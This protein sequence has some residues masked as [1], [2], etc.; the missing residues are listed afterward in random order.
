M[1]GFLT[2][3]FS[4]EEIVC[5]G[6]VALCEP[7]CTG[8]ANFFLIDWQSATSTGE[9]GIGE[10]QGDFTSPCRLVVFATIED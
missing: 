2:G 3:V 4:V 7:N 1:E 9:Q 6:I 8:H 10:N 5:D